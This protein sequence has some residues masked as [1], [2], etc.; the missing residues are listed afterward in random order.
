MISALENVMLPAEF[1]S[2]SSK[3]TSTYNSEADDSEASDCTPTAISKIKIKRSISFGAPQI[4]LIPTRT[5]I[6]SCVKDRCVRN[7]S[8]PVANSMST[9]LSLDKQV[10]FYKRVTVFPVP[11]RKDLK[12][13]F[14]QLWYTP[15]EIS[16]FEKDT[17]SAYKK[18][19]KKS[20]K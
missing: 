8:F 2:S 6:A 18:L 19:T 9:K 15:D 7:A 4:F 13:S 11:S 16:Q 1:E 5:E 10:N 17:L 3:S 12:S 14:N 20:T